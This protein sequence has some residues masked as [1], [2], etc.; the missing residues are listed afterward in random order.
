MVS[1]GRINCGERLDWSICEQK[2]LSA[3][4]SAMK[5][6]LYLDEPLAV[7][8]GHFECLEVAS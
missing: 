3:A 4:L 5:E 6:S 8:F 1:F 2:S 7:N